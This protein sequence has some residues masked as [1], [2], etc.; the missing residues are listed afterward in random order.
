MELACESSFGWALR[1]ELQCYGHGARPMAVGAGRYPRNVR[2]IQAVTPVCML[3]SS[4]HVL[5]CSQ[6][7]SQSCLR[8]CLRARLVLFN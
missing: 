2:P 8:D 7:L 6:V 5:V 4:T 3:G 1:M